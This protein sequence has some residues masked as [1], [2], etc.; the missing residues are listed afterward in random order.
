MTPAAEEVDPVVSALALVSAFTTL[1]HEPNSPT[2][3]GFVRRTVD[4]N[5]AATGGATALVS[6]VAGFAAM[7]LQVLENETGRPTHAWLQEIGLAAHRGEE[8]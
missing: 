4:Q 8:G 1:L 6:A 5:T 3:L 7:F 2:L